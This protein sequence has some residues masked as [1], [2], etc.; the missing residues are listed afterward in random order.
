M[1][2]RR[3]AAAA[4]LLALAACS[5]RRIPGTEILDNEDT[6]AIVAVVDQYKDALERRDAAAVLALCSERYFDDV[7]TPDPGDDLDYVTLTKVIPEDLAKIS[8]VRM[9][10]KVTE[11]KVDGDKAQVFARYESRYRVATRNGDVP[12][13]L[14]DVN[15]LSFLREKGVWRIVGGL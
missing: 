14:N 3:L 5:P 10:I 6:R 1:T 7:G 8:A 12:K 9:E 13:A 11:I 15:R 4:A 2:A